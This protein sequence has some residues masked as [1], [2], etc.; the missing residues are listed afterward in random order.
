MKALEEKLMLGALLNSS[1]SKLL[2]A[3]EDSINRD[4]LRQN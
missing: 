3:Y 2:M 4:L 1:R